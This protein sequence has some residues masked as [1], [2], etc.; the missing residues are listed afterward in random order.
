VRNSRFLS[1]AKVNLPV[2]L[3]PSIRIARPDDIDRLA[4]IR[5]SVLENRLSDPSS[6]TPGDYLPYIAEGRCWVWPENGRILGFVALDPDRCSIWGLFVS[7]EASGRGIGSALLQVAIE[8]ARKFGATELRIAT[9]AGT[10][11]ERLYLR[12]GWVPAGQ[13]EN[14]DVAM[15][16][17]L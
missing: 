11:A 3:Q 16:L 8:K 10:L 9:G 15:T 13:E 12:F 7:P 4:Q 5:S 1:S 6:I 2:S 14:G 17:S